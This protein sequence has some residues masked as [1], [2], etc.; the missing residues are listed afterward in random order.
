MST[1]NNHRGGGGGGG[2]RSNSSGGGGGQNAKGKRRAK[3]QRRQDD[4]D[5]EDD[6][7]DD[8][9]RPAVRDGSNAAAEPP[10]LAP[11]PFAD[12]LHRGACITGGF[13][14]T[15]EAFAELVQR[16]PEFG[17]QSGKNRC[18]HAAASLPPAPLFFVA[19]LR[20]YCAC[21]LV[22]VSFNTGKSV[23]SLL[24]AANW[25]YGCNNTST[26]SPSRPAAP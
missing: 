23:A 17:Y 5:D 11:P 9:V 3:Q 6:E 13:P 22:E 25:A 21:C 2:G 26:T 19:D 10:Q 7:D 16:V 4:N 1:S 12:A 20:C 24:K 14:L 15:A 18:V 8:D